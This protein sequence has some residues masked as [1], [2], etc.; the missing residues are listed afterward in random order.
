M[1]THR[2]GSSQRAIAGVAV[3]VLALA[4]VATYLAQ[5]T[6]MTV[7]P[8]VLPTW[9]RVVAPQLP[10]RQVLL[11]LPDS[12]AKESPM[13]WQAVNEM[14]YSMVN[15][16]GPG[17]SVTRAGR[18]E[19]GE[20]LFHLVSSALKGH[21][22]KVVSTA[23]LARQALSDWRVTTIVLP[24]QSGLPSYDRIHLVTYASALITELTG[25]AP[26]RQ[27]GAWVWTD[28]DVTD[29]SSH[30][31]GSLVTHCTTGLPVRGSNAVKAA[32]MC[33]LEALGTTNS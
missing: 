31:T 6:P 18:D 12:T 8:V 10:G 28:V 22:V 23:A 2:L 20:N 7:R 9:F 1:G 33:V 11:I 24:D 27:V 30:P 29:G 4:P 21:K 32:A 3:A 25:Q 26:H 5:N 19:G 14:H 13:T 16:G 15:E 17:G